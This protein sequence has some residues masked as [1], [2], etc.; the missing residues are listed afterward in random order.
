MNRS[1]I[2]YRG[3]TPGSII[4]N[5]PGSNGDDRSLGN[6]FGGNSFSRNAVSERMR[7]IPVGVR[8]LALGTA[9]SGGII[10]VVVHGTE[11]GLLL[12]LIGYFVGK[13]IQS[14]VRAIAGPRTS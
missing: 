1:I 10:G 3:Q 4:K 6:M 9:V 7:S 2:G 11:G 12:A 13:A 8:Y 14:T 5:E